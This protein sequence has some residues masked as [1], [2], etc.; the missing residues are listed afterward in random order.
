LIG[1]ET[2]AGFLQYN[3]ILGPIIAG[4]I[5]LIPN[6]AASVI[7]TQLYLENVITVAT[8]I[9]GLLVGAGVGLAVLFKINK[10]I[11]ENLKIVSFPLKILI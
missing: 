9:S 4:L 10:G 11:K 3:P 6:C 1:E 2:I 8:M 7:L 5:G